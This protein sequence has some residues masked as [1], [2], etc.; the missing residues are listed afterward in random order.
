MVIVC[1]FTLYI[2][3]RC[4]LK[5]KY[6]KLL[7][8]YIFSSLIQTLLS[9]VCMMMTKNSIVRAINYSSIYI[10]IIVEL[11]VVYLLLFKVTNRKRFKRAIIILFGLFIVLLI[12]IFNRLYIV[13]F[14]TQ[15][16]SSFSIINSI[17]IAIPCLFYFYE[18]FDSTPVIN[19][20]QEP[21]FWIITGFLFMAICTLPFYCLE[22]YI[23]ENMIASYD[24]L[25]ILTYVFYCV[26]FILISKALLCKQITVK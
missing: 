9:F 22:S 12:F 14:E 17:F 25:Y 23:Y 21:S 15:I 13:G 1:T 7:Q 2:S 16:P 18:I 10:F 5:I 4:T 19:L 20:S 26:L 8:F 3:F 6:L 24:Q 11:A